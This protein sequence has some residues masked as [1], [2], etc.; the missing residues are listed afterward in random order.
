MAE[1]LGWPAIIDMV[2]GVVGMLGGIAS[3]RD[4]F[5]KGRLVGGAFRWRHDQGREPSRREGVPS[6]T[7]SQ[8]IRRGARC[9]A[10]VAGSCQ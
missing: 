3:F 2:G 1:P 6:R 5:Y 9:R 10:N 8:R 7:H 4:S